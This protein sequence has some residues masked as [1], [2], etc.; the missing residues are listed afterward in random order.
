MSSLCR[1]HWPR[2]VRRRSADARLLGSWVRIL[3]GAWR[4]DCCEC[5][6][7]ID[8][9]LCDELNTRPEESYRLWCVVVCDL[10][11]L[12]NEEAMTRGGLQS[13]KIKRAYLGSN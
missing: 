11:N 4:F 10:E 3:T 9:G 7:L 12:R 1:L 8:R 2:G 6:V 13:H 5:C